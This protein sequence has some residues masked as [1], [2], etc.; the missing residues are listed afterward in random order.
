MSKRSWAN[1]IKIIKKASKKAR[2]RYKSLSKD[3]KEKKI[4]KTGCEQFTNLPEHEKQKLVEYK[5]KILQNEKKNLVIIIRNI[6]LKKLV[7]EESKVVL[8][9]QF[10]SYKFTLKS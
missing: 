5:K 7:R 8:K 1:I 10:W 2:E 4:E 3:K 9:N 6:C